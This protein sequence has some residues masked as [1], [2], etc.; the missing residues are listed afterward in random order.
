M[1]RAIVN[2]AH[3]AS[4]FGY[5]INANITTRT[6]MDNLSDPVPRN[7]RSSVANTYANGAS[8]A[9]SFEMDSRVCSSVKICDSAGWTTSTETPL[10]GFDA[11]RETIAVVV[12]VCVVD[13]AARGV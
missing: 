4:R 2:S 7:P 10:P 6:P 12:C 3:G 8:A 11:W 1:T 5:R 9:Q 13:M